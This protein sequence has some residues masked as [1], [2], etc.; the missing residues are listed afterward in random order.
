MQYVFIIAFDL[1]NTNSSM[2][3]LPLVAMFY[4]ISVYAVAMMIVT[5]MYLLV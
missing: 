3:D 1:N 4:V 5:V 2:L